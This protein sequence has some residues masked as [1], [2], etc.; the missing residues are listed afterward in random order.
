MKTKVVSPR[1]RLLNLK[2][3]GVASNHDF[4]F[5]FWSNLNTVRSASEN[6]KV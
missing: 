1:P 5:W 6:E 2:D 4:L 3:I